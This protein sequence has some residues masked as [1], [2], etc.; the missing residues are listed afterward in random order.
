[1]KI[2]VTGGTGFLGSNLVRKLYGKNTQITIFSDISSHIFLK[3]LKV[4]TIVGD[5]RDYKAVADA[6]KGNDF[7]YHLAACSKNSAD[8]KDEIFGVNEKGTENVMKACLA[9]N[10]KK[11]VHVSSVSTLGFTR[12]DKIK[13][14]EKNFLASE[15][16][17]YGQSKKLGEDRVQDYVAKGL[18]ASIAIPAYIAGAGEIE[19]SRYDIFKSISKGKIRFTYP[20]GIGTVAVEDL[21]DGILLAMKKGKAGER[22]I[23]SNENATL[24]ECY[25]MIAKIL[26]TAPITIRLPKISYYPAYA[27]ALV[28]ERL[29]KNPP[30]NTEIVR[31]SFNFR[32]YDSSKARREL[33]WQPKITLEESLRR[34]INY[35]RQIGIIG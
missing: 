24:F 14:N 11:A 7:V 28:A 4:K 19:K 29:L 20:G 34:A 18:D 8:A 30:I 5:V 13:L 35:Y 16:H 1:M 25:N 3:G 9:F 12:S 2:L 32:Y 23:F 6:V 31:W 10:V 33:G 22:Y 17:I 21:C 15:D 27:F 26:K